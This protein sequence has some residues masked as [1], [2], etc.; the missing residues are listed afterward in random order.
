M[1]DDEFDA[2]TRTFGSLLKYYGDDSNFVKE[3]RPLYAKRDVKGMEK[4]GNKY[5]K[6]FYNAEIAKV[7]APE[8]NKKAFEALKDWLK[9][10][11]FN[12][13][14]IT[15]LYSVNNGNINARFL[16]YKDK[17]RINRPVDY[18]TEMGDYLENPRD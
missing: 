6:L 10:K 8:S 12:E 3:I 15:N 13:K 1:S 9:D 14:N 4:V 5:L 2:Y 17:Y 7:K 16:M 11:V 18:E